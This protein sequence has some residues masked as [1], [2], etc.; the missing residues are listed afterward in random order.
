MQVD[1]IRRIAD[2]RREDRYYLYQCDQMQFHCEAIALENDQN[3]FALVAMNA[4]NR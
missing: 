2:V 3:F 1:S 4:N